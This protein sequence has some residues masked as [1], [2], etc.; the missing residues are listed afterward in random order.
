[1]IRLLG[2]VSSDSPAAT[3]SGVDGF[4]TFFWEA[5]D[6]DGRLLTDPLVDPR[7]EG[8]CCQESVFEREGAIPA[9]G[10]VPS[11]S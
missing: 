9:L 4:K 2:T 8:R 3:E 1:M 10:D 5:N 6:D 7:E 11:L